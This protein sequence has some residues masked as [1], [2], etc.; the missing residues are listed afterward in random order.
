MRS[1]LLLLMLTCILDPSVSLLAD[2]K[3]TAPVSLY[4]PNY[5]LFDVDG[6]MKF[7]FSYRMRL[8]AIP[9]LLK[10][11]PVDLFVSHTHKAD[12]II[13]KPSAPFREHNFNP[14]LHLRWDKP[15]WFP[16][17]EHAQIGGE[18]ESTGVEGS[19]SRGWNR[20]TVLFERTYFKK[21]S[22]EPGH[23]HAYLRGWAII[24]KDKDNNSDIGAH[25]GYGEAKIAYTV[26]RMHHKL[27][28]VVAT[29]TS[30]FRSTMLELAFNAPRPDFLIYFQYFHGRGEW[31]VN[32]DKDTYEFRIGIRF[33][34][35]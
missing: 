8:S 26:H 27:G 19:L 18:H 28:Q 12:W 15:K 29:M 7:Q 31:L 16:Y 23:V 25:L 14:E 30:R 34:G 13:S 32:Y 20:L 5:I 9:N 10:L 1:L 4:K 35:H 3:E 6:D 2:E 21:K 17:L 33:H 24:S 22:D 11:G